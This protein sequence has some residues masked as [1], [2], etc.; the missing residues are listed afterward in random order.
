MSV[1]PCVSRPVDARASGTHGKRWHCRQPFGG[2]QPPTRCRLYQPERVRLIRAIL[3]PGNGPGR[4]R[5]PETCPGIASRTAS[6]PQRTAPPGRRHR[7]A[8]ARCLRRRSH[9]GGSRPGRSRTLPPKERTQQRIMRPVM[10]DRT[11]ERQD[12]PGFP[13][14]AATGGATEFAVPVHSVFLTVTVGRSGRRTDS[15]EIPARSAAMMPAASQ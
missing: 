11:S 5:T 2:D 12:A 6:S 4:G 15:G 9:R 14:I 7:R 10:P 13:P 3:L 8:W 1:I